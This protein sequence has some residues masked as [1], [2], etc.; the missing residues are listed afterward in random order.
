MEYGKNRKKIV[1][2]ITDHLH[3]KFINKAF[4]DGV[5]QARFFT[6]VMEAYIE[7]DAN[8]RAFV[9]SNDTFKISKAQIKTRAREDKKAALLK[10]KLNLD[11]ATIDEI[12]D[13]LEIPDEV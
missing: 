4:H 3:A 8:I 9:E 11:Q 10:T 6:A 12:F 1:F 2:Y 5:K 7:D 13:I